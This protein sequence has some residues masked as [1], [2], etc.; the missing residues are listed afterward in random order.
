MTFGERLR[1]DKKT[2]ERVYNT[3]LD[4]MKKKLKDKFTMA[5]FNEF[6]DLLLNDKIDC[7]I[8]FFEI[9]KIKIEEKEDADKI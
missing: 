2:Y 8:R 7:M 4:T 9:K 6:W 5:L 1:E 3:Q